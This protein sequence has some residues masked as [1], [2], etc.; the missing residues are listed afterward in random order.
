MLLYTEASSWMC[1]TFSTMHRC[2]VTTHEGALQLPRACACA[3]LW[4]SMHFRMHAGAFLSVC[5]YVR[6]QRCSLRVGS[7]IHVWLFMLFVC[8][9]HTCDVCLCTLVQCACRDTITHAH[10]CFCFFTFVRLGALSSV[11]T[12]ISYITCAVFLF[13]TYILCMYNICM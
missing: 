7:H 12:C 3:W 13:A 11:C 8:I 2:S 1:S 10:M 6:L 9:G 5:K 4:V